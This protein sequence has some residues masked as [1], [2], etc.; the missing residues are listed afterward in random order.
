MT[1]ETPQQHPPPLSEIRKSCEPLKN[2]SGFAGELAR[3]VLAQLDRHEQV[4][5]GE[6]ESLDSMT[7]PQIE[8]MVINDRFKRFG[9]VMKVARS[10][11]VERST[12][13]RKL[14]PDV[15]LTRYNRDRKNAMQTR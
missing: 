15:K 12:V 9:S 14:R 2:T 5:Q 1:E 4:I 11:G 6:V 10:A 8:E 13:Y 7:I 3:F